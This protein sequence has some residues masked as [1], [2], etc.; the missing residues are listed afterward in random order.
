MLC[1]GF[2]EILKR[3]RGTALP[4]AWRPAGPLPVHR[5]QP[6]ALSSLPPSLG[7]S[8]A[9]SARLCGVSVL[10]DGHPWRGTGH[11][12]AGRAGPHTAEGEN[13]SEVSCSEEREGDRD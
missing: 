13:V 2:R 4:G 8:A 12:L 6:L 3:V 7:G 1:K 9:S 11:Q 10:P 5:S